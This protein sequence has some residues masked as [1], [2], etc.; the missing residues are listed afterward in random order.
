MRYIDISL[1][2]HRHIGNTIR[3]RIMKYPILQ[4]CDHTSVGILVYNGAGELLMIERGS[5]PYG[6]AIPAGHVD[7][8]ASYE[9]AA[10]AEVRE[11]VGLQILNLKLV[12]EGRRENPCRRPGGDWHYWKIFS[13]HASGEVALDGREVRCAEWCSRER[14]AEIASTEANGPHVTRK[15]LDVWSGWFHDLGLIA[16]GPPW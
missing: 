5:F 2:P 16:R 12:A 11:E 10:L 7:A 13:G 1:A 3:G 9:Q 8:Y 6:M 15:L 4:C 14:L